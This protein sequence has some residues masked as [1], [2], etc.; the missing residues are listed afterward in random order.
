[1]DCVDPLISRYQLAM[2]ENRLLRSELRHLRAEHW[3]AREL[4]QVLLFESASQRVEAR[5]VREEMIYRRSVRHISSL[6]SAF[7]G[8]L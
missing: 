1:M 8:T 5:S 6:Q 2:A 3:H 4:L 7:G